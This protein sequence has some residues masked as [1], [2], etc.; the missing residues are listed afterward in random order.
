[1]ATRSKKRRPA[2]MPKTAKTR[3]VQSPGTRDDHPAWSWWPLAAI[4][5]A[6]IAA[7]VLAVVLTQ[8]GDDG[9]A[10]LGGAAVAGLP[11]TPDYHSL[12]VAPTDPNALLLGTHQGLYRSSDGGQSFATLSRDVGG[13]VMALAITRDGRILAG[14]MQQGLLVT[15]DGKR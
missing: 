11:N 3:P 7:A 6:I 5:V 2:K 10:S 15:R 4:A 12:L 14:D 8:R 13:A 1:M 9:G